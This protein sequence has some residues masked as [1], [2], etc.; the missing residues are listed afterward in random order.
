M[1]S[2]NELTIPISASK[3]ERVSFKLSAVRRSNTHKMDSL[4]TIEKQ[5]EYVIIIFVILEVIVRI[6]S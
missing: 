3:T 5:H 4:P 6:L 2:I 1:Q